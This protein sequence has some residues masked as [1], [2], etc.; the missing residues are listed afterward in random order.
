MPSLKLDDTRSLPIAG[1]PSYCN[2]LTPEIDKAIVRAAC[3]TCR[4]RGNAEL[5]GLASPLFLLWPLLY[6]I[7]ASLLDQYILACNLLELV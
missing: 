3:W 5:A 4:L 1:Q 2:V 6:R 7:A